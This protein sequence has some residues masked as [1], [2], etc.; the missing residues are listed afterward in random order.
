MPI[1]RVINGVVYEFPDNTSE[2]TIRRFEAQ[3]TG[4]APA[5]PAARAPATPRPQPFSTTLTEWKMGFMSFQ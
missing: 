2:A 4:G 5:T 1:E 3:K